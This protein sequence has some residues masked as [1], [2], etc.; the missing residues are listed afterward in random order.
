MN[1]TQAGRS[2][3][4]FV[5]TSLLLFNFNGYTQQRQLQSET[6]KVWGLCGMCKSRIETS[7]REWGIN[8]ARWNSNT[9]EL[10]V[11]YDTGKFSSADIQNRLAALG[12][13]TET[14]DA[15]Q[16]AYKALPECCQYTRASSSPVEISLNPT[17]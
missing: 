4:L 8:E 16:T 7:L 12:H 3:R 6:I 11:L 13:A 2:V 9:L 10:S 14:I 5:L 1:I 17:S 15:D